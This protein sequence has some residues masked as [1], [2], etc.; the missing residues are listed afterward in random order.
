MDNAE[1][2][3]NLERHHNESFG[4]ALGCC[5]HNRSE[6]EGVLQAVY[7]KVLEGKARFDG[8]ASFRT[9]LF[10]VIRRTA[11]DERRRHWLRGFGLSKYFERNE[12]KTFSNPPEDEIYRSQVQQSF[13]RAL[14]ELPT[15]QREIL[16]LIFYYDLSLAEA[17]DVMGVSLG[18]ARTHYDRGKQRLRILMKG[19]A[20]NDTERRRTGSQ[21]VVSTT[22]T[23]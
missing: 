21:R 1:L 14:T 11:A 18:S 13:R 5:A 23:R 15:R 20:S 6:A 4:W 9:W 12:S 17:A 22:E 8:T 3:A 19:V 10:A 7:L 16:Q 2:R